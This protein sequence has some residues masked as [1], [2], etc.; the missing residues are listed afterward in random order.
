MKSASLTTTRCAGRL[1]MTH[2][3]GRFHRCTLLYPRVTLQGS[4]SSVSVLCRF[5]TWRPVYRVLA[6]IVVTVP[7]VQLVL[8]GAGS[9]QSRPGPA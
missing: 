8:R 6:K 1:E 2:P 7:S 4:A 5:H 3:S 9:A